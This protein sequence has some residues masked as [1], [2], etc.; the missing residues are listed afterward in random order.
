MNRRRP[1]FVTLGLLISILAGCAGDHGGGEA[2]QRP[3]TAVAR[4]L[5]GDE[6]TV[7]E[8]TVDDRRPLRGA[9]LVGPAGAVI[10]ADSLDVKNVADYRQPFFRQPVGAGASD[11]GAGVTL[12]LGAFGNFAPAGSQTIGT[13]QIHSTALIRLPDPQ[14]YVKDWRLWQ[15]RL[16]IGDP[17]GVTLLTL[18][19]PQPPSTL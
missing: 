7:I 19:A 16:R 14:S 1:A 12:P 6:V 15:V 8:V 3:Y 2:G 4:F 13:G 10:A 5:P 17:P 9:D 11:G 18:P